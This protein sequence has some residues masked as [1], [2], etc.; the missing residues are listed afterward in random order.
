MH[1]G[2]CP[3]FQEKIELLCKERVVIFKAQAEEGIGLNERTA[4]GDNFCA[5]PRDEIESGELL[6]NANGVGGTENGNCAG[7]TDIFG[8]RGGSG[9]DDNGS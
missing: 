7:E 4:T 1:L 3:D 2:A 8:A 6:E 9:E 5:A